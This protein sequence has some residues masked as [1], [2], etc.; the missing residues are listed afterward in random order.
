MNSCDI[1][2]IAGGL[3]AI[4]AILIAMASLPAQAASEPDRVRRRFILIGALFILFG[5]WA[6][7]ASCRGWTWFLYDT[8]AFAVVIP[9]IWFANRQ[10]SQLPARE[11]RITVVLVA[12]TLLVILIDVILI[13]VGIRPWDM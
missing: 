4:G 9:I 13:L 1:L 12:C 8:I 3:G 7:G 10:L 5:F 11:R 2:L 6:Q